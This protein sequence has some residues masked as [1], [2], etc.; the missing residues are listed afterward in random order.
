VKAVVTLIMMDEVALHHHHLH[1]SHHHQLRS[2][3][4]SLA[5]RV[6]IIIATIVEHRNE[7]DSE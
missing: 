7:S 5:I 1:H 2:S 4:A 6:A 3:L